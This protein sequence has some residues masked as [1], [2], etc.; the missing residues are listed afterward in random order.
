MSYRHSFLVS[1]PQYSYGDLDQLVVYVC[2]HSV[3]GALG[4]ILNKL[5][6]KHFND[7]IELDKTIPPLPSTI[8]I[9]FG[10][11][12]DATK[13]FLVLHNKSVGYFNET[14]QM[15]SDLFLTTSSDALQRVVLGTEGDFIVFF[16]MIQW[17]PGELERNLVHHNWFSLD[18]DADIIFNNTIPVNQIWTHCYRQLGFKPYQVSPAL[19]TYH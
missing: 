6:H 13:R 15:G 16:G 2:E 7:L 1:A 8:P 11:P 5:H 3:K 17:L 9:H 19:H 18:F 14:A 4:L 10:G 12:L